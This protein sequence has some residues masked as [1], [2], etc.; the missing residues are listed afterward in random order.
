[1]VTLHSILQKKFLLG[2]GIAK[3]MENILINM[4]IMEMVV[5]L[6]YKMALK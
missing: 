4:L 5:E 6:Y 3:E 2:D 1:V